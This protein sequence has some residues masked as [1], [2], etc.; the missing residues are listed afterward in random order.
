MNTER[1]NLRNGL[2]FISPWIIGFLCFTAYPLFSSLYYSFTQYN[3]ISEPIFVGWQNYYELLFVDNIFYT[4]LGNTLYMIFVGLTLTTIVTI[5]IAI[6]LNTD[7]IKG[8]SFFRVVFFIPTLV[9]FVVLAILWIWILQPDSGVVNSIL[10]W[11][12]ID[13]PGWFA[14]PRWAKPGFILMTIWMSGNMI[15]IY[16][17]ALGDIPKSLYEAS[18]IDGANVFQKIIH[19]TLPMLRPAILFNTITGMI[20]VFQSFAEAFII[21]DGGPENA[22]LFYSLYL[23]RNAFQYF[24]MGYASAMAW[25]LLIIALTIT[26]VFFLLSKRWE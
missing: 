24:N 26:L 13:G 17:A 4:V 7:G 9:P 23:Y 1:R 14:S 12:G 11:F 8:M 15:L 22:T 3:L 21:T 19:I 25:I 18:S 20:G 10:A 16:L 6:L 5:A 2:L